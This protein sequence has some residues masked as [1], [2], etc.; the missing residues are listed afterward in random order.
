MLTTITKEGKKVLFNGDNY[1][2]EWHA[3][4]EKRGLPN[5]KNSVDALPVII[6]KDTVELFAKY[7]VYSERELQ[8]R[9]A[10]LSETY[11]KT[12]NIEGQLT[13]M[14]A[15]TMILPASLR[16]Q[17]E[18]AA[19]V[20]ATKAAGVDNSSQL[21]FLKTLTASITELQTSGAALD[22]ALAHHG[23]S[24]PFVHAKHM[25]VRDHRQAGPRPGDKL[26]MVWP[27][28]IG[29]CRPPRDA[30]V[31][32]SRGRCETEPGALWRRTSIPALSAVVSRHAAGSRAE[33]A[34]WPKSMSLM[35][36]TEPRRPCW[37]RA[38]SCG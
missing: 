33:R 29:R 8:S 24:Y 22:K 25:R 26:E 4:A 1:T 17:A 31:S 11:A 14:M 10:I 37:R 7:K 18:V 28:T 19:A 2:E 30:F 12:I 5:I 27:T 15:R 35:K 32:K 16:Y 36:W 21:E 3:E 13:S 20:N 34:R 38:D 23:D 6:R 9:Y